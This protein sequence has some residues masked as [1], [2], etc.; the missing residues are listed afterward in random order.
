MSVFRFK[1]KFLYIIY[2]ALG[3]H[4]KHILFGITVWLIWHN[5]NNFVFAGK[6]FLTQLVMAQIQTLMEDISRD[7]PTSPHMK[8]I[9]AVVE[10]AWK[11]FPIEGGLNVIRMGPLILDYTNH[12]VE[13]LFKMSLMHGLAVWLVIWDHVRPSWLNYEVYLV[14]FSLLGI[15]TFVVYIS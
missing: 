13:G 12:L 15:K 9:Y 4:N 10:V 5:R 3:L 1:P 14:S 2:N 7:A 8:E 6:S 11:I